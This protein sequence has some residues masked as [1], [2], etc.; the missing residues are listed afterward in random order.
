MSNKAY[1]YSITGTAEGPHSPG[2]IVDLL[3]EGVLSQSV[4]LIKAGDP[5]WRT[6]SDFP[7]VLSIFEERSRPKEDM[8]GGPTSTLSS[9]D[10]EKS[11]TREEREDVKS[12]RRTRH[13]MLR[14]IRS[15]LDQLWDAQREAIIARIK[16]DSLDVEFESTRKSHKAIFQRIEENVTEYW[17][18]DGILASWIRDLTWND[19]D[20]TLKFKS[21]EEPGKF[22]EAMAWLSSK[23]LAGLPAVYCFISG[24]EYIYVGQGKDIGVRLKQHEQKTFFTRADRFRVVIPQNKKMLNKLERLIILNRQPTENRSPGVC[25]NNPADDCMEFIRREIKELISDF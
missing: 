7:D 13:A 6:I 15:S 19:A 4:H 1:F 3:V 9:T 22:D 16:D 20:F 14:T 17:R 2:E 11:E 12:K 18:T 24:K 25:K 21:K 10:E 8:E 5:D 23:S